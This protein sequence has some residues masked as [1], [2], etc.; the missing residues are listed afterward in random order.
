M[1]RELYHLGSLAINSPPSPSSDDHVESKYVSPDGAADA[2]GIE[3]IAKIVNSKPIRRFK[4]FALNTLEGTGLERLTQ[5]FYRENTSQPDLQR[6][7]PP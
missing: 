1:K 5:D 6:F 2:N 7:S 4:V 3:T